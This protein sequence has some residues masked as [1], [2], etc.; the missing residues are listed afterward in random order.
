MGKHKIETKIVEFN[1]LPGSGKSTVVSE[2]N[3]KIQSEGK[4]ICDFTTYFRKYKSNK[5]VNI[6][7]I[8]NI[9]CMCIK[10]IFY[11]LIFSYLQEERFL[12]KVKVSLSTIKQFLILNYCYSVEQYEYIILDQ[13]TIQNLISIAYDKKVTALKYVEKIFSVIDKT[14]L[15]FYIVNTDIDNKSIILRLGKREHGTSRLDLLK[16]VDLINIINIQRDNFNYIRSSNI[17]LKSINIDTNKDIS[18]NVKIV[19]NFIM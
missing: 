10:Y 18:E 3:K 7:S 5:K 4:R 15:N 14:F 13:G 16:N 12:N 8:L 11:I 2:L 17:I 1:G 19:R 6:K 9:N